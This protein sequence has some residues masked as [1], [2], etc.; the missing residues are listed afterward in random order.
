VATIKLPASPSRHRVAVWRELRRFG[1]VSLGGGTWAVP[2]APA[3]AD[4]LQRVAEL[5]AK[6]EGQMVRFNART[7][8]V[9]DEHL[10]QAEFNG[11]R[12]AEWTEFTSE[13]GKFAEEIA[14]EL[15][16]GKLTVAELDEEEHNLDRLRRWSRELHARDIFRVVESA[17]ADEALKRCIEVLNRYADDIYRA[18]HAP[19]GTETND[20]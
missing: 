3:F 16:I 20:A 12:S 9:A 19:L 17:D 1:A 7:E 6:A 8:S 10:V 18:V 14:K 13:C 11:A 4:G 2:A 5:V 15:R